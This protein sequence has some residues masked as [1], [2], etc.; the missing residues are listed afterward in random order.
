MLNFPPHLGNAL[1]MKKN[2]YYAEKIKFFLLIFFL[3]GRFNDKNFIISTSSPR[4]GSTWIGNILSSMENS[5]IIFEPLQLNYVPESKKAGFSWRTY[6]HPECHW[7][8]GE[9]YL[10]H[11]F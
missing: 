11:V 5:C 7:K 3:T 1:L 10:Q 9:V 6:V 2:N 8:S 4:S